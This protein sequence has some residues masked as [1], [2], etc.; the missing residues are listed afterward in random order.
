MNP[1]AENSER[2]G[3]H[4]NKCVNRSQSLKQNPCV[5]WKSLIVESHLQSPRLCL[6]GK[7]QWTP[8]SKSPVND[9]EI[10]NQGLCLQVYGF[11][12]WTKPHIFS[13]RRLWKR[14]QHFTFLECGFLNIKVEGNKENER[15]ERS[16]EKN[17]LKRSNRMK[18]KVHRINTYIRFT[19]IT[20]TDQ[21]PSRVYTGPGRLGDPETPLRGQSFLY[22]RQISAPLLHSRIITVATML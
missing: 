4:V 18:F 16:V 22:P 11:L 7:E 6:A 21:T 5:L 2:G 13:P 3:R 20:E 14:N 8:L 12:V 9:R 10:S 17:A 19:R 1:K 15:E